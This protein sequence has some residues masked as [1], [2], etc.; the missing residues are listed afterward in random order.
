MRFTL[1][2]FCFL[3]LA[4]VLPA[5]AQAAPLKSALEVGGWI[6]YWTADAGVADVTPA[7]ADLT[8]LQPFGYAVAS[9]GALEDLMGI[10]DPPWSALR[11]LAK[12]DHVRLVPTVIWDDPSSMEKILTD[13]ASRV[14]LEQSVADL[15]VREDFDGIDIDFEDKPADLKPYFSLFLKGLYQRMGPKWVYCSIEAAPPAMT[16]RR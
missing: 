6:P 10:A 4:F 13:Q 2:S 14:A 9:N 12:A 1:F 5:S 7:I 11:A 8:V 3:A 15:A 16:L